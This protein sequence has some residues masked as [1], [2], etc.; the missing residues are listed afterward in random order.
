MDSLD[1]VTVGGATVDLFL[2]IDP[3][4]PHFKFN[5]QSDELSMHLGDK[6]V[7]DNAQFSLGGNACNVAVG[8]KKLGLK[9]SVIAEI[10]NDEFAQKVVNNLNSQGVDTSFIKRGIGVSSFSVILNYRNDRTIFTEKVE[11]EHD[12]SFKNLSTKWIYLT[13]LGNKWESA[14][15]KTLEFVKE[16]GVS[17]AFNPG[18][19]QIDQGLQTISYIL[20]DT[21][22][23]FLNKEEAKS[24]CES[25]DIS[26]MLSELKNYG[27]KT[28]V[29]TAGDEGSYAIDDQ[30]KIYS[31]KSKSVPVVSK[32]GAGDA[33]SSGFLAAIITG[34]KIEEAMRW[35]TK[36]AASVLGKIGAQTGLLTRIEIEQ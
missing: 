21:D 8:V 15:Q 18:S 33:Y 23:L 26:L 36:N 29:I 16:N 35:G 1:V 6:I 10:G 3:K 11:K 2:L 25:E 27:P 5:E 14:Y 31:Q 28:V 4:N 22:I 20:K 30:R 34:A 9:S 12:F 7:L 24:I 19:T 17:L 13:S 32:T